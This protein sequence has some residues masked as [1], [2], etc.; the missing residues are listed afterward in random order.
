MGHKAK[1]RSVSVVEDVG[2]LEALLSD[3]APPPAPPIEEQT[4][5]RS[6]EPSSSAA[7]SAAPSARSSSRTPAKAQ[8]RKRDVLPLPTS[9][10]KRKGRGDQR[11]ANLSEYLSSLGRIALLT[12]D[13]EVRL[14]AGLRDAET[15]C[16]VQLLGL[17]EALEALAESALCAEHEGLRER[18]ARVR[19]L[20]V[21][22]DGAS[23][24]AE[25]EELASLLREVD[26]DRVVVEAVIAV[27]D[28]AAA[29]GRVPPALLSVIK[30]CRRR[31]LHVRNTFVRAN[32]RLVVSVARRF[33]HHRLPLVDLI[34]EGN[35]GL[36]KSVHRFDH[37]RGFRF[38]TYAHWWIR[39]AIERSIMNKGA[40]VR[41]PVHVFDARREL[42]HV[43]RELTFALGREPDHE[44]LARAMQT[45]LEKL[46]EV[47][48]AVPRDPQSLDDPIGDDEDRTL[49]EAIASDGPSPDEQVI[50]LDEIV[51]VKRLLRLLSP[52]EKDI[53]TR[54]YGLGSDDDETLEEIGRSYALSRERVRQIQVQGLKKIQGHLH[55]DR[56]DDPAVTT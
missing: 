8:A 12:A 34:Q 38:S 35:L 36:I 10:D 16:W 9:R 47:M 51:R 2:A 45:S 22:D 46:Y 50:A 13:D 37:R 15:S 44:E 55:G 5:R 7:R 11:D 53:L 27:V 21:G 4:G 26:D 14:A 41:L 56:A 48:A 3:L 39:Q 33:H 20:A 54:R 6:R 32:L 23:L 17:Q 18:V 43:T 31:A 40:Q 30:E 25:Q 19:S 49:A 42:A 52:M 1:Q 24:A 29:E 28:A